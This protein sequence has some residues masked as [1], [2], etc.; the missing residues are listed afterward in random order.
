MPGLSTS[1]RRANSPGHYPVDS[2]F[3]AAHRRTFDAAALVT[4]ATRDQ[5]TKGAGEEEAGAQ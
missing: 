5:A 3:D 2:H 4:D 1:L